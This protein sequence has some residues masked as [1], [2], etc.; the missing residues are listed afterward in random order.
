MEPLLPEGYYHIYNRAIADELIFREEKNYS[1]FLDKY[2]QYIVPVADTMSFC[3]MPNHFHILIRVKKHGVIEKL[4]LNRPKGQK[5]FTKADNAQEKE[6][7]VALFLSKQF[8]N[9]FSS[10]TQAY[11]LVYARKGSLFLK[12]FKRKPI[13]HDDYFIRL[14]NYIHRNPVN[15]GFVNKPQQWKYSSY[16]AIVSDQPTLVKREE[17]LY[18]FG[19]LASFMYNH[20]RS[21]DL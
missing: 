11:N 6:N 17:V 3:L 15:H 18:W 16:N 2:R 7:Y 10:Y 13:E 21:M 19:G 20:L 5:E 1:F 8:S 9:L 4:I 12:N 14:V